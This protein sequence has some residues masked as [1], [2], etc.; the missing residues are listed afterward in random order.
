VETCDDGAGNLGLSALLFAPPGEMPT[1]EI[2]SSG[3]RYRSHL[4]HCPRAPKGAPAGGS[5]SSV[6]SR[7][8]GPA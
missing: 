2:V 6:T 5:F 8:K 4:D 7:K 3:T 1:A